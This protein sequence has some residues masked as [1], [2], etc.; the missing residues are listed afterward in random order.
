MIAKAKLFYRGIHERYGRWF[1]V[2]FFVAGFLFDAIALKRIDE[3]FA[4]V[5]QA[6]YILVA[7]ILIGIELLE[8]EKPLEVPG[9]MKRAWLYREGL[10]QFMFG[11]LL[12]VYTIFYFKSSSSLTSWAFIVVMVL[13]LGLHEFKSFGKYQLQVHVG[14]LTLCLISFLGVLAPIVMGFI[15]LIP[16]LVANGL[17]WICLLVYRAWLAS[18]IPAE[19]RTMQTHV[20]A[21]FVIVQALFAL[22]YF[23]RVLPPVPLSAKYIGIYHSAEKVKSEYALTYTRPSDKFWQHGDQTFLARPGDTII[24]FVEIFA[25]ARFH[26]RLQVRWLYDDPKLGWHA[27]DAIPLD[28]AGGREEGFRGITKKNNYQPGDWRVQ[29]DTADGR[30]VGRISFTVETDTSV[31]PLDPKIDIR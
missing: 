31:D 2:L 4:L 13:I 12:N 23:G 16:F 24:C 7:S 11:T 3:P 20:Y 29:V 17:A 18:R 25:P 9:W 26:D 14:V 28:V 10:L 1:P 30:E 8:I 15:G 21:P 22:L 6:I 19:Q 27:S 5:Q